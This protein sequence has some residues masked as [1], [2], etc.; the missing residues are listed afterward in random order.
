MRKNHKNFDKP[1]IFRFAGIDLFYF[2]VT[3]KA[4]GKN[5]K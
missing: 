2:N 5:P 1:S 4:V 3:S